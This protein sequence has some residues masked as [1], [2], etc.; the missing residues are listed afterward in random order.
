VL[1]GQSHGGTPRRAQYL[2]SDE[3]MR[4]SA[5]G[6]T[7]GIPRSRFGSLTQRQRWLVFAAVGLA[8]V[9]VAFGGTYLIAQSI[10]GPAMKNTW[11]NIGQAPAP[12][13]PKVVQHTSNGMTVNVP[14]GWKLEW[15][16]ADRTRVRFFADPSKDVFLQLYAEKVGG[17]DQQRVW[18]AGERRQKKASADYARVADFAPSKIGDHDSLDWEWRFTSK[19]GQHRHVLVRGVIIDGTS[20]QLYYSAPEDRYASGVG[21]LAEA[22]RSFRLTG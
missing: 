8:I 18:E 5:A 2:A 14:A 1:H 4:A 16:T 17:T 6:H 12:A 3:A 22:A 19:S 20:Y 21:V 7:S 15:Q 10:G 9:L 13:A 11:T